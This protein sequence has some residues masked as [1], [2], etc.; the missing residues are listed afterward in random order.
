MRA[1]RRGPQAAA[2]PD[3]DPA[4]R[5]L[6]P[7]PPALPQLGEDV[8]YGELN[9]GAWTE[10]V[11]EL[12]RAGDASALT[13]RLEELRAA[14][15]DKAIVKDLAGSLLCLAAMMGRTAVVKMLLAEGAGVDT[16][17]PIV[18]GSPLYLAVSSGHKGVVKT[19]VE[20]RKEG[21]GRACGCE[22]V[23]GGCLPTSAPTSAAPPPR[24]AGSERA[25]G[26]VQ[27][28]CFV[29]WWCCCC[30]C[31]ADGGSHTFCARVCACARAQ[32][33]ADVDFQEHEESTTPLMM[34][35]FRGGCPFPPARPLRAPCR[36]AGLPEL[37]PA[38]ASSASQPLTPP[39]PLHA[40]RS[41]IAEVLLNAG[42]SVDMQ[43]SLGRSAFYYAVWY[44]ATG[45]VGVL[46][47]HGASTAIR[48]DDGRDAV[49]IAEANGDFRT[50]DAV[51]AARRKQS[52]CYTRKERQEALRDQIG[53]KR[54]QGAEVRA[55]GRVG[56]VAAGRAQ[57]EP[58][59]AHKPAERQGQGRAG[60]EPRS[61]P[62]SCSRRSSSSSSQ[63]T[64]QPARQALHPL[65][66]R[67]ARLLCP[68]IPYPAASA[69]PP[70]Q[71][72][73]TLMPRRFRS[74]RWHPRLRRRMQPWRTS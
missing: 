31:C 30:C 52:W 11:V 25:G 49:L 26:G 40:D 29:G 22:G 1:A 55:R 8:F 65:V 21:G 59:G 73:A 48:D 42:A 5:T 45:C 74:R 6:C 36:Q 41:S 69:H 20:A 72:R 4:P 43:D 28:M 7:H 18:C 19:L 71:P 33:G 37:P 17:T 67:A 35:C 24:Q 15:N 3:L 60:Q 63:P 38:S 34:T 58:G 62:D 16:E 61:H 2:A 68:P 50:A 66:R 56:A 14:A 57:G 70:P 64:G 13:G 12:T 10:S 44:S 53:K 32:A 47:S 27:C 39:P 51:R 23:F 46:A 9:V 54:G